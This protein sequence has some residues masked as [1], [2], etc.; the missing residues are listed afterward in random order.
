MTNE[1]EG[2]A[3]ARILWWAALTHVVILL[4]AFWSIYSSPFSDA[5]IYHRYARLLLAGRIPYRDYPVEYPPLALAF[6]TLPALVTRGFEQYFVAFRVEVVLADLLILLALNAIARRRGLDRR[7]V[8][9]A[10]TVFLLTVGPIVAQDFDLFP[11]AMVVCALF[12]ATTEHWV[13]VWVML[14]LGVMTKLYPALLMPVFAMGDLELGAYRRVARHALIAA[15]T[16]VA[17]ALPLLILAP[18]D[19]PQFLH[20]HSARGIHMESV[21]GSA[22]VAANHL[23]LVTAPLEYNFG[24]W[25]LAGGVAAALKPWTTVL[26]VLAVLAVYHSMRRADGRRSDRDACLVNWSVLVLLAALASSKVLSP[27]YLVWLMPLLPLIQT[28]RRRDVWILYAATGV[29]TYYIFP[30]RYMA[31]VGGGAADAVVALLVRN[32]LLIVLTFVLFRS[33]RA[34][35]APSA[36]ATAA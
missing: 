30:V 12:F 1:R 31:L 26:M 10:Y 35:G 36:V 15:G 19:L 25:N 11:T 32:F 9:A 2:G 8:L 18:R 28:R 6:F 23:R 14:G 13:G 34:D 24:S 20:Y 21:Y 7:R 4:G 5:S 29:V 16:C 3:P 27:Q 17:S 33:L 22:L